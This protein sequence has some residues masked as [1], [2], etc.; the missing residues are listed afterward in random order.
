MHPQYFLCLKLIQKLSNRIVE[1]EL[2][3]YLFIL[4]LMMKKGISD[5]L[6]KHLLESNPNYDR[7]NHLN[8]L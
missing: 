5:P 2:M 3:K 7:A 1:E 8:F 4:F 6:K